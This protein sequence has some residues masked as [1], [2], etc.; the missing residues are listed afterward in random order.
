MTT[1]SAAL[2]LTRHGAQRLQQRGYRQAD[3]DAAMEIGTPAGSA[4]VVTD[5]DVDRAV[6][7]YRRKIDDIER[8]RGL[9]LILAGDR[10]LSVYRPR[11][12]KVRRLL[13]QRHGRGLGVQRYR[14]VLEAGAALEDM[15]LAG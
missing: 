6:A 9:A 15:R 3:V 2:Q 14:A 13:R 1:S 4:I 11:R 8:L 10:V 12:R 5:G 7:E